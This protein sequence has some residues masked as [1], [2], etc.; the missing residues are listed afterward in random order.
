[1]MQLVAMNK[2]SASPAGPGSTSPKGELDT[3]RVIGR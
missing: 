1:M 2:V 3:S